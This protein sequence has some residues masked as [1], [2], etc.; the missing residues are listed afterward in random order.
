VVGA[1]KDFVYAGVP[2]DTVEPPLVAVYQ[3]IVQPVTVVA[4]KV[5]LPVPQRVLLLAF[6]GAPGTAF[7]VMVPVAAALVQP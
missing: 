5:T 3:S 1:V 6:V 2:T 7:T 4:L